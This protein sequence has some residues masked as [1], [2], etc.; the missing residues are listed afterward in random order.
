MYVL[1]DTTNTTYNRFDTNNKSGVLKIVH[2][3]NTFLFVGDAEKRAEKLLVNTYGKFLD[4]DVLKVGHHGSKTS[5]SEL[6]LDYTKPEIALISVGLNNKFRHPSK[7]VI[8]RYENRNIE[9]DRTDIEGAIIYQSDG[10]N[11][12]KINWKDF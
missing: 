12:T 1:N 7:I 4:V 8:D 9:I 2:G 5:S 3:N 6:F 11:I 10:K